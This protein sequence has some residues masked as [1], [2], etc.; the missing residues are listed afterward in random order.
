MNLP[1]Q[2]TAH[3]QT[4]TTCL[5]VHRLAS[6]FVKSEMKTVSMMK[7]MDMQHTYMYV[8]ASAFVGYT[9]LQQDMKHV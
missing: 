6:S 9:T 4:C 8:Q 5:P 1:W 7:P 3:L 2:H